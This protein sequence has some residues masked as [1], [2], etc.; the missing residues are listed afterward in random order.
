MEGIEHWTYA[1]CERCGKESRFESDVS[2]WHDEGRL[3]EMGWGL[4]HPALAPSFNGR[5]LKASDG[6]LVCPD[7]LTENEREQVG[8][9]AEARRDEINSQLDYLER[10]DRRI[11]AD[12][13]FLSV[14]RD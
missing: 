6:H 2:I 11:A 1:T 13:D 14:L 4:V 7:C 5:D 12:D 8:R 10:R 3:T 9:D